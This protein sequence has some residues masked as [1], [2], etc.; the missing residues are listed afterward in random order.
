MSA[1][2]QL[3]KPVF[4]KISE[5]KPGVHCFNVYGKILKATH[6]TFDRLSGDSLKIVEGV[7]ADGSSSAKFKFEGDNCA[8]IKEGQVIAIRNG[9]SSIVDEHIR[10]EVDKFGRITIENA[11]NVTS[12]NE[13]DNISDVA[14]ERKNPRSSQ[15]REDSR[16]RR[17]G[18][19][20][21]RRGGDRRGDRDRDRERR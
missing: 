14:Y 20:R 18:G 16:D 13:K 21:P 2:I 19:D 5:I 8:L 17:R 6:S 1:P 11:S 12:V 3:Q 7:V 4:S 15:R 10:L 9:R